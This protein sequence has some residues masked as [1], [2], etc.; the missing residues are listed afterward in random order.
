MPFDFK[1]ILPE[2]AVPIFEMALEDTA[3]AVLTRLIEKGKYA[4]NWELQ[5]IFEVEPDKTVLKSLMIDAAI[6]ANI[7]TPKLT[8][9]KMPD[10]NWLG[11]LSRLPSH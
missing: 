10:I 2:S 4:G 6:R 3:G 7:P 9:K 1:L 8:L 11:Q 5:A